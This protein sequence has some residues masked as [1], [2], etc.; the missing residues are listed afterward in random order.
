M[1]ATHTPYLYLNKPDRDDYV[2]V[3]TDINDNMNKIDE[4]AQMVETGMAIVIDGD[5]APKAITSGQYLFIKNHST[6][7]TGG[8]HATSNISLGASITSSNVVADPDGIANAL[9]SNIGTVTNYSL[10]PKTNVSLN[11]RFVKTNDNIVLYLDQI[12]IST[13]VSADTWFDIA[14]MTVPSG[15]TLN[16]LNGSGVVCDSNGNPK[17]ACRLAKKS[18]EDTIMLKIPSTINSPLVFGVVIAIV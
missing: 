15:V 2:N 4:S 16:R 11:S 10:T 17:G 3:I 6:L 12:S 18:N 8:Y 9:N 13:S 1:A 14:T 5:E 7:A